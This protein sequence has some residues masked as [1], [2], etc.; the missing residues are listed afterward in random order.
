[1]NTI[2]NI[3]NSRSFNVKG[4]FPNVIK[5]SKNQINNKNEEKKDS[6]NNAFFKYQYNK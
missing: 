1:M 2:G 3:L 6:N 5:D 4:T